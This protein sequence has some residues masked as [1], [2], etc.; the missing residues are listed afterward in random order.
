MSSKSGLEHKFDITFTAVLAQREKQ[1]QQNYRPIIGIHKWFARRPGTVFRNLL[2]SE[3]NGEEPI[4]S[5]YWRAHQMKGIIAD[6]FMGG[7][8]P[9]FEANRLGFSVVGT[10]INP[11]SYW[12]V[13]QSLAPLDLQ[14]FTETAKEVIADVEKEIDDLYNTRCVNCSESA[15]VKYFIW[16]KTQT[17]PA[18]ETDNDLF[19]GY[20]LS[21]A[22]RHTKNVVVCS[23]CGELNEYERQPSKEE[24]EPCFNCSCP[25]YVQGV[26]KRNKIT[27]RECGLI[28]SY[29]PKKPNAPPKHR[30]WAIEYNCE[31]CKPTNKGRFFKKP[32]TEDLCKFKK[33]QERFQ[34]IDSDLPIP[35]EKIPNGDETKR[36]LRWGY[37]RFREMFNDRQLL[38]LGLLLQRIMKV[39]DSDV[40]HALLTVFSDFLRYQNMLCRYDTYALKCQDIFSVHGFPVG[41]VQCENNLLGIPNVGAGAFRHF[42]EKY[43]RAK[44]YCLNPFETLFKGHKKE[45]LPVQ[46]EKII[47]NFVRDFPQAKKREAYIKAVTA[48]DLPLQPDSIDGVFTDPP[49]FDNVQYAELMDFCFSWLRLGLGKEFDIFKPTTTRARAELTGNITMNRGLE[50]F[51][52]G[53]SKV[54]CHYAAALKA[55]APFVFTYHHNDPVAYVPLVVAILDAGLDCTATFPVPAEMGASLHIA[56]SKSSVLDT[57]FVCRK[58]ISKPDRTLFEARL[59]CDIEKLNAAGLK[60]SESDIRCLYAGHTA[61]VAINRLRKKWDANFSLKARMSIA[62]NYVIQIGGEAQISSVISCLRQK[63]EFAWK[64]GGVHAEAI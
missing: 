24:P 39:K 55:K 28:Y 35:D 15:P 50:S 17:C 3:F 18:C 59:S 25:V 48:T 23:Q 57:V 1:I 4:E 26:A 7:G 38:G 43:Q 47:A 6:P 42:L 21:A 10:D 63:L 32:D 11:M 2:L 54:F 5:G 60:V 40:R 22:V 16:V 33:A 31:R 14:L 49:Y 64:S 29:P 52:D 45:R 8:T 36:L 37:G 27:C 41:L 56:H 46:G 62:N 9:I 58:S 51:T 20:L 61:R 53:L 30:M 19:P 44:L 12:I 13:R 34:N